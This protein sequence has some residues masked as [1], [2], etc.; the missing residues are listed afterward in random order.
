MAITIPSIPRVVSLSFMF[1]PFQHTFHLALEL[2]VFL[3]ATSD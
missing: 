3:S 2:Y 1:T